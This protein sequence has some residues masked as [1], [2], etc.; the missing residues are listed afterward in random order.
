MEED[1]N[2]IKFMAFTCIIHLLPLNGQEC[3]STPKKAKR[4]SL[5][6]YINSMLMFKVIKR[7]KVTQFKVVEQYNIFTSMFVFSLH[8]SLDCWHWTLRSGQ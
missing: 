7:F 5:S 3:R 2:Q 4:L 1:E 8:F 6:F